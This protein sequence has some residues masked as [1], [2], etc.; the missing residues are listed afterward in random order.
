MSGEADGRSRVVL[1]YDELCTYARGLTGLRLNEAVNEEDYDLWR[2][3]SLSFGNQSDTAYPAG[4]ST[5]SV[6]DTAGATDRMR[7]L[8]LEITQNCNS[9]Y[10]KCSTIEAY[11]RQYTYRTDIGFASADTGSAEGM[12]R[13]ADSFL[14]ETG[15][16]YCV[17]YASSMVMLLRLNGIPARYSKGYRYVF[18]EERQASYTVQGRDAHAWPEAYIRGFGWVGFEPTSIWANAQARTW[19]RHPSYEASTGRVTAMYNPYENGGNMVNP[20]PT[21]VVL[22]ELQAEGET[23]ETVSGLYRYLRMILL[24]T[25]VVVCVLVVVFLGGRLLHAIRY[26]KADP[27]GRV[28]MDVEDILQLI[29][30]KSGDSIPDRGILSDYHPVIPDEFKAEAIDIFNVY[31]KLKY[32]VGNATPAE[33]NAARDLHNRLKKSISGSRFFRVLR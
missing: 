28:F 2:Q 32:S 17:N 25:A 5:A 31:Y 23:G 19:H 15:G 20:Y 10:E 18:P 12:S 21:P 8:A 9:D 16:G 33:E 27:T 7:K 1:S 3:N 24:L 4:E 29:R 11:L 13:I 14:F 22:A 30:I 6:L 26:K